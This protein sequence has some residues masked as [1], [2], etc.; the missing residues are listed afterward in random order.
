MT[1]NQKAT[2]HMAMSAIQAIDDTDAGD[3]CRRVALRM[4]AEVLG[5]DLEPYRLLKELEVK[6]IYC[7]GVYAKEQ[8]SE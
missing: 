1:G 2:I 4:L 6:P 3:A 5:L 7:P 8:V